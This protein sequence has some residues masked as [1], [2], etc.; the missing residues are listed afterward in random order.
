LQQHQQRRPAC[1]F[2]GKA[3]ARLR[4]EGKGGGHVVYIQMEP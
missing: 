2:A 4:L 1:D 3:E